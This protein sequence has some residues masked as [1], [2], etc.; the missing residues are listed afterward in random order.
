MYYIKDYEQH[1]RKWISGVILGFGV[2]VTVVGSYLWIIDWLAW[3]VLPTLAVFVMFVGFLVSCLT[4]SKILS[5]L[6]TIIS[7]D[8]THF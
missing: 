6:L 7:F 5:D 3:Y 1:P 4:F 8:E 2:V